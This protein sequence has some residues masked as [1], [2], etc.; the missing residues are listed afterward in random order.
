MYTYTYI[1][2]YTYIHTSS[3]QANLHIN[4]CCSFC[5]S[6]AH[7]AHMNVYHHA[8][9]VCI[10]KHRNPEIKQTSRS[11]CTTHFSL[12]HSLCIHACMSS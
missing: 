11:T 1:Y 3:K 9:Y 12:T 10:H 8:D 4:I 5:F 2:I 7:S 6:L